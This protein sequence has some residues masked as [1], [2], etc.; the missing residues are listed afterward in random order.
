LLTENIGQLRA[1][2]RRVKA[3]HL[4]TVEAAVILPGQTRP[5]GS[6]A[7][8]A[9]FLFS[10]LG[11]AR[12]C[13]ED[14][15]GSADDQIARPWEVMG[16]ASFNPSYALARRRRRFR[17]PLAVDQ[18]RVYAR[19]AG[20]R[21]DLREPRGEERA[22]NLATPLLGTHAARRERFRPTA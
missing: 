11:Q 10:S 20:R 6:G 3:R 4:F 12:V 9:L 7:G 14:W 13:A 5:C 21:A 17:H 18:A 22:R 2:S 19:F 1:A 15:A 16:F 8:L